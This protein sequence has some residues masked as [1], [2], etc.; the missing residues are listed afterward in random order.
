MGNI[1]GKI[2]N[3][4]TGGALG[5]AGGAMSAAQNRKEAKRQRK[6]NA[7]EAQKNRDF[8]ETMS[9]TSVQRRATDLRKAGFNRILSVASPGAAQPGGATAQSYQRAQAQNYTEDATRGVSSAIQVGLAKQQLKNMG[10][11]EEAIK[12]N[13]AKTTYDWKFRREAKI[14][15]EIRNNILREQYKGYKREGEID[16]S[17]AGNVLRW[18]NRIS[19]SASG[20]ARAV[21]GLKGRGR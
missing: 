8:Q 5:L 17:P 1:F 3:T 16:E 13:I 6:F 19:S 9:S 21:P 10:W 12:A 2:A 11:E 14:G 20:A 4:L 7:E 15:E 18:M